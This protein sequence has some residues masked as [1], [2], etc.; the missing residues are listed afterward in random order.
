MKAQ[1]AVL[2]EAGTP[3]EVKEID[4]AEPRA[5]E[6][7]VKIVA[8]GLCHSDLSMIGGNI[9]QPLPAVPGHEAAGIVAAV[10]PGVESVAEG[11]HVLLIYRPFC[12][13]CLQCSRGRPALCSMAAQ[14]RGSGRLLDGSSRLSDNGTELFHFS[15]VSAFAERAV[16][17]ESGVIKIDESLPLD[18]LSVVGCAVMTG[19]G[20]VVNAAEVRPGEATAVI[21]CGGVGLNSIQ[22]ARISGANPII[23]IDRSEAALA[24]AR[25]LGATH[26]LNPDEVDLVPA[27]QA[28][29]AEG[30]DYVFEAVGA[31]PLI[32]LG[33]DLL[34]PGGAVIV[35]G[36][37]PPTASVAISP[38][39][40]LSQEKAVIGS[41]YGSSNFRLDVPRILGLWQS[42][43]LDIDTLVKHRYAL[44]EIN[45]GFAAMEEGLEGRAILEIA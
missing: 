11:D 36:A 28:I 38:L 24:L 13:H 33:L 43:A 32:E 30:V 15:G 39:L 34:R 17:P 37:P 10:G 7:A 25:E 22:G 44:D 18:V 31:G 16:V 29:S 35:I 8:A 23:A 21:G 40:L 3:L 5:G 41:L 9:P 1:A 14:I 19:Y 6:V 12:G 42:G 26:V 2:W 27:V 45:E 4:V 20:A